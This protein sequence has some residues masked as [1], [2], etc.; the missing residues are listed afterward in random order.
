MRNGVSLDI[1]KPGVSLGIVKN[2][3]KSIS[4]GPWLCPCA[5]A[6]FRTA[7]YVISGDIVTGACFDFDN[8]I[9]MGAGGNEGSFVEAV[10]AD[11]PCRVVI[12]KIYA[13]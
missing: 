10:A 9:C 1:G 3:K 8:F 7:P 12:I 4:I 6:K 2:T 13:G 11:G 5:T